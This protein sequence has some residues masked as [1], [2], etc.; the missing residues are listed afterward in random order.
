MVEYADQPV[1][2]AISARDRIDETVIRQR[3]VREKKYH[4]IRN[5]TPGAGFPEEGH[6]RS[7]K[8][9]GTSGNLQPFEKEMDAWFGTP[10]WYR[11][12]Q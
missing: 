7:R 5:F 8:H 11:K 4:Y 3:S 9:S 2:Y 6:G 12:T 10:D 1:I